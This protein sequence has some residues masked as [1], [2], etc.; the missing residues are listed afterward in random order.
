MANPNKLKI[1]WIETENKF[2]WKF[3]ENWKHFH[4]NDNKNNEKRLKMKSNSSDIKS[5]EDQWFKS[6]LLIWGKNNIKEDSVFFSNI[7][8]Y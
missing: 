6:P 7:L 4:S 8:F 1:S 2:D 3:K 5:K